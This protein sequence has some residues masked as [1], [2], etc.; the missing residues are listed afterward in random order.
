IVMLPFSMASVITL[1]GVAVIMFTKSWQ[2]TLL[3][4]GALPFLNV[5]AARFSSRVSPASLEL[6]DELGDLS[7]VVEDSV[8][9]IRA[10]KGFG[11][12]AVQIRHLEQ[13]TDSV[14][15]RALAVARLRSDFLPIVDFIPTLAF[16]AILWYGGH[17]VLDHR[18]Q[19]GD[20]VA[21]NL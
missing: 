6:Q 10:V 21:Y 7:G 11:A 16:V 13:A 1:A 3:A 12:E 14:L 8:A 4:L 20:L 17:L 5:V 15:D 9:G 18:L 19:V 2:L